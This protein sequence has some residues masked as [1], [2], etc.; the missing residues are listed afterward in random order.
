VVRVSGHSLLA[1]SAADRWTR[2]PGSV[3]LC[4]GLPEDRTS[5]AAAL[6]TAKHEA[7]FWCLMHSM[8]NKTA[9][10]MQGQITGADNFAFTIDDEFVD[11]VNTYLKG[12][13]AACGKG[14]TAYYELPLDTSPVLGVSDQGGTGDAVLLRYAR[15][16]LYVGD[17]KFG[18]NEVAVVENRQLLIYAAAALHKFDEFNV[19]FDTVTLAI[20][21]PRVRDLPVE[22]TITVREVRDRI[23]EFARAAHE[24]ITP[25][26]RLVPGDVQCQWCPV[27]GTCKAKA[28][29][30][31]DMFPVEIT[32]ALPLMTED[33]LAACL[34]RVD[35]IEGWCRD[36][37]AE[38][39]RRA[40]G[41]LEVPGYKL[42]EG[43]R[44]N[45]AWTDKNIALLALI[46][47]GVDPYSKPELVSPTE[48]EKRL[49]KA[50]ASYGEVAGWLVDQPPGAPSLAK[51]TEAGNPLPKVEFGTEESDHARR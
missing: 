38:A 17:A 12:V 13:R 4:K 45:R 21:Q 3:Q 34:G 32:A 51:V 33:D 49:K 11:H 15:R 24:A 40:R 18:Y 36:V 44:G 25:S 29:A 50:G 46:T 26:A 22:W 27:R 48:A 6:G 30:I 42:I 7:A 20:H 43:R 2:C 47:A 8:P 5:E 37:R 31:L 35:D 41:G 10:G 39:L 23:A 1:P 19:Q 16:D 9:D 28:D 14:D